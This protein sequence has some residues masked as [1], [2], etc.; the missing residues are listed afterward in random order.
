MKPSYVIGWHSP[1]FAAWTVMLEQGSDAF[2]HATIDGGL[3]RLFSRVAFFSLLR[4]L[5]WC[6]PYFHRDATG[7]GYRF[8]AV[9]FNV[10]RG[11]YA[12]SFCGRSTTQGADLKYE[13]PAHCPRRSCFD[14]A[15]EARS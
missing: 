11:P 2:V 14:L 6:L 7:E 5:R 15:H 10:I 12:C 3:F 9:Y 4:W 8:L 1:R 13:I